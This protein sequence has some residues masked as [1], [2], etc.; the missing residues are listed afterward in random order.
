MSNYRA[1]SSEAFIAIAG[2]H[3]TFNMRRALRQRNKENSNYKKKSITIIG[4]HHW[5]QY[6]DILMFKNL[7]HA[8]P[9]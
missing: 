8:Q 5:N 7:L 2:K 6:R 9:P 1:G 4:F 3:I